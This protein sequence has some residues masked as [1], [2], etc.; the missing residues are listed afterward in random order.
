MKNVN[1]KKS[2]LA[3][4]VVMASGY[5]G[6][7]G[8]HE[9]IDTITAAD[10]VDVVNF[11]CFTDTAPFSPGTASAAAAGRVLIDVVSGA[12][13]AQVGHIYDQQ[14][15]NQQ[16]TGSA[17]TTAAPVT[18]TPPAGKT[19]GIWS[20]KGYNIVVF[21]FDRCSDTVSSGLPLR[22][23]CRLTHWHRCGIHQ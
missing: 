21:S 8:A 22:N 13:R 1:L 9:I 20:S 6:S 2:V 7:A 23:S 19:A 11:Q 18:L 17:S 10:A 4:A 3:V 14:V 12:V 15:V 16:W 5:M